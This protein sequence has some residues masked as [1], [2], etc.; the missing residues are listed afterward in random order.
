MKH[1]KRMLAIC[2][3]AGLGCS[4][5][6]GCTDSGKNNVDKEKATVD[7]FQFKVEVNDALKTATQTYM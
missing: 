5:V 7:I 3:A 2:L 1:L 6:T 4:M